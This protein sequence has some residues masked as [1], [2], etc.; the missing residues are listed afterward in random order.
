MLQFLT[1]YSALSLILITP[2]SLLK[3]LHET[4]FQACSIGPGQSEICIWP[5]KITASA[6]DTQPLPKC[7]PSGV[8]LGLQ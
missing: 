1:S 6:E 4:M 7:Q 5:L 2:A 8:T 3:L